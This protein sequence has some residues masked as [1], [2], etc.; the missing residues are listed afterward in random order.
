MVKKNTLSILETIK[1]KLNKLD[2]KSGIE[3]NVESD[4][5]FDYIPESKMEEIKGAEGGAPH[6]TP[7]DS[8]I[9][10]MNFDDDL[11]LDGEDND[12]DFIEDDSDLKQRNVEESEESEPFKDDFSFDGDEGNKDRDLVF[13]SD[14]NSDNGVNLE[15]HGDG[16][17]VEKES[18]TPAVEDKATPSVSK[19]SFLDDLDLEFED[20]DLIDNS[21]NINNNGVEENMT[22][23]NELEFVQKQD[24]RDD[25]DLDF[26]DDDLDLDFIDEPLSQDSDGDDNIVDD[27]TIDDKEEDNDVNL[28]FDFDDEEEV[29]PKSQYFDDEEDVGFAADDSEERYESSV[30]TPLNDFMETKKALSVVDETLEEANSELMDRALQLLEPKLEQWIKDNLGPVVENVVREEIR[31]LSGK[32][33]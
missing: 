15:S 20:D 4:G 24:S 5:E 6:Y 8:L 33:K 32:N 17:N 13:E 29:T 18:Q 19:D 3:G 9:D 25:L 31:Y 28:D 16:F 7:E 30:K 11:G 2:D 27:S 22:T 1:N 14:E 23:D 12:P 21:S 26:D 10:E